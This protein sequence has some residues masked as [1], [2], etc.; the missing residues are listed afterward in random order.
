AQEQQPRLLVT[1][2]DQSPDG[3]GAVLL[4]TVLAITQRGAANAA[5]RAL[6]DLLLSAPVARRIAVG[7]DAILV[8]N[9]PAETPAGIVDIHSLRVMPLNYA[10]LAARLPALRTALSAASPS[11]PG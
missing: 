2:P 6:F 9:D 3:C 7:A 1:V 8:L 11:A 5:S 10:D 4:P